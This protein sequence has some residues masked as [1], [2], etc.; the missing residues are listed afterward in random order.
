[1]LLVSSTLLNLAN[2]LLEPRRPVCCSRR[3]TGI[4][5]AKAVAILSKSSRTGG[6]VECWR[7]KKKANPSIDCQSAPTEVALLLQSDQTVR[8]LSISRGRKKRRKASFLTGRASF[9]DR[10]AIE[11]RLCP[12][13]M[14]IIPFRL[15]LFSLTSMTLLL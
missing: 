6:V 13:P 1:M 3:P 9:S 15:S 11:N 14:C 8:C 10:S 2:S 5:D 12:S 4:N 7:W